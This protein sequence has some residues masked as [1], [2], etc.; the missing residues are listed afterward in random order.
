[1]KQ[2]R[3]LLLAGPFTAHALPRGAWRLDTAAGARRQLLL[4]GA[5]LDEFKIPHLTASRE[6]GLEW[7]DDFVEVT[8]VS[9]TGRR[10]FKAATAIVHEARPTLYESL[11][12]AGFDAAARR[13]WRRVFRLVRI[14]G[15]RY[16]LGRIARRRR[17]P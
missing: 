17:G 5:E 6:I 13:F 1:M 3:R 9:E 2:S 11:P 8:V 7:R 16:I 15:G 14:P 10:S 12:L 4:R